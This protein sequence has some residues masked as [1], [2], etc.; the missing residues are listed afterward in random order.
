MCIDL[1]SIIVLAGKGVCGCVRKQIPSMVV[2]EIGEMHD[3]TDCI[4]SSD[5]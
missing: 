3:R 1:V 4:K 2:V 5:C